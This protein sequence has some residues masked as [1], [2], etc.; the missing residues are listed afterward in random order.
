MVVDD[1]TT[2]VQTSGKAQALK[3]YNN[4]VFGPNPVN[5]TGADPLFVH[6]NINSPAV[7]SESATIKK[8]A[9]IIVH[10]V[11]V[12][13]IIGDK[14]SKGNDVDDDPKIQ[15]A[16]EY[17]AKNEDRLVSVQFKA[18]QETTWTDLTGLVTEESTQPFKF[19]ADRNNPDLEKWDVPMPAKNNHRG[20]WI[21]KLLL[22]KIPVAGVFELKSHG[23]GVPPYLQKTHFEITVQ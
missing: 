17:S 21:S 12:N 5:T 11:G 13:F 3:A 1:Y 18:K 6:G 4:W 22:L 2:W 8:D 9:L 23:T 19:D 7:R 10:V 16:C 14:D 15:A 20:A